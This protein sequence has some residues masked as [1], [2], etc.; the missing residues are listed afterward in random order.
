MQIFTNLILRRMNLFGSDG[1][2]GIISFT[3][4]H[5]GELIP[6]LAHT[7]HATTSKHEVKTMTELLMLQANDETIKIANPIIKAHARKTVTYTGITSRDNVVKAAFEQGT[8][9]ELTVTYL[10][11]AYYDD[12]IDEET[13][14]DDFITGHIASALAKKSETS[15]DDLSRTY[16][17]RACIILAKKNLT[18]NVTEPTDQHR[19]K[20]E[21]NIYYAAHMQWGRMRD[22]AELPK[23]ERNPTGPRSKTTVEDHKI[24]LEKVPFPKLESKD[25]AK[26]ALLLLCATM[27]KLVKENP[28]TWTKEYLEPMTSFRE[29]V[30]KLVSN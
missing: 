16:Y 25:D 26:K 3:I 30:A 19:S 17:E 11:A 4:N 13:L 28:T 14:K 12:G 7:E 10:R 9:T 6:A 1:I 20:E 8:S 21:Q 23:K 24:N 29:S 22:K 2:F 27:E 18:K 15:F 5:C